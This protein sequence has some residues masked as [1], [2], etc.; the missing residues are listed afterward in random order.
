MGQT[1]AQ[2]PRWSFSG[3]EFAGGKWSI[4]GGIRDEMH[5]YRKLPGGKP[6][7]L[8]RKPY[9][10]TVEVTF[11]STLNDGRLSRG[12]DDNYPGSLARLVNLWETET[13]DTLIIPNLGPLRCYCRNWDREC[14]GK[15]QSGES[16]KLELVEDSLD[17]TVAQSVNP[18]TPHNVQ[19]QSDA[20]AAACEA[21]GIEPTYWI[22]DGLG[23]E[24]DSG[25]TVIE[26]IQS[27][28]GDINVVTDQAE[29][30]ANLLLVDMAALIGLFQQLEQTAEM[31]DVR[32]DTSF[33]A[34]M[35]LWGAVQALANDVLATGSPIQSYPVTR[36]MGIDEV[37]I[38]VY[39]ATDRSMEIL[40]LNALENP[41]AIP[42]GANVFYYAAA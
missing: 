33:S 10:I 38:A 42:A 13:T 11:D 30:N 34:M 18:P 39:G 6:E 25:Q 20:F 22:P 9:T 2:Y 17:V 36:L 40:G 16:V 31:Q 3:I 15:W 35:D 41:L 27:L 24:F 32:N 23:G 5:E 21:D 4:K 8:G 28:V 7:K 19:A 1:L 26:K 14:D 37:A 29:L 12:Y